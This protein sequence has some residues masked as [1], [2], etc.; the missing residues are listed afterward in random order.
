MKWAEIENASP[1]GEALKFGNSIR[2]PYSRSLAF[3]LAAFF[4][5]RKCKPIFHRRSAKRAAAPRP[6]RGITAARSDLRAP[7]QIL[8][9]SGKRVHC[10]PCS[11]CEAVGHHK[12]GTFFLNY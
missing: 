2:R 1:K 8:Y 4:G 12:S 5:G 3:I 10:A 11:E 7:A 9:G 6:S